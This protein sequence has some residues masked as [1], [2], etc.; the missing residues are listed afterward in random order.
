[1]VI[2]LLRSCCRRESPAGRRG[3]AWVT[4]PEA[5]QRIM[6]RT[7]PHLPDLMAALVTGLAGAFALSRRDVSDTLPGVA[8]AVSQV[9]HESDHRPHLCPWTRNGGSNGEPSPAGQWRSAASEHS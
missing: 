4:H 2:V 6:I 1:M 8:I 3:V 9:P 5:I 7:S